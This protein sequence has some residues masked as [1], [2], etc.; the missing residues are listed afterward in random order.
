MTPDLNTRLAKIRLFLTDVDG[1]LTD[2]SFI[3]D[4]KS[5]FKRFNVL[6]GLGLKLLQ[7]ENIKVGWISNRVSLAT[8]RRAKELKVDFL[9]QGKGD[10]TT[11]ARQILDQIGYKFEEV[12][13]AGDDLIDLGLLQIVGVAF[14]VPGAVA[15][16]KAEADYI[17]Q[18]RGGEG[19]I[20]EMAEVILKAQNKWDAIVKRYS[21]E[22]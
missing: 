1:V 5:E 2:G 10:K 21:A 15:E 20:R 4:E 14:S 19:A 11:V 6:D 12:A 13:Y 22:V 7:L 16:A 8:E 18:A 17:T 9:R 3:V